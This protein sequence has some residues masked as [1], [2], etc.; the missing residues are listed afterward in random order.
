MIVVMV[1]TAVVTIEAY[2]GNASIIIAGAITV[3][4]RVISSSH[5]DIRRTSRQEYR[6]GQGSK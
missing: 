4:A 1:G 3:I 6:K 5:C 2:I